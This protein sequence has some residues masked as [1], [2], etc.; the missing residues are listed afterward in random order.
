MR[1]RHGKQDLPFPG[2]SFVGAYGLKW[3][4]TVGICRLHLLGV[5]SFWACILYVN[6]GQLTSMHRHKFNPARWSIASCHAGRYRN[7]CNAVLW[8]RGYISA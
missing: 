1:Q 8:P 6:R 7:R 2:Y 4:V 3:T 5:A